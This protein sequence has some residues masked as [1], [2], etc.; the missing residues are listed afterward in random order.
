MPDTHPGKRTKRKASVAER[1]RGVDSV[2]ALHRILAE[3]AQDPDSRWTRTQALHYLPPRFHTRAEAFFDGEWLRTSEDQPSAPQLVDRIALDEVLRRIHERGAGSE[4]A[5]GPGAPMDT[6]ADRVPTPREIASLPD[7]IGPGAGHDAIAGM[8]RA[9]RDEI[10]EVDARAPKRFR[11]REGRCV[12]GTGGRFTYQFTWS[13]EPEPHLPGTLIV[14]GKTHRARVGE[15]AAEEEQRFAV[16]TDEYLGATIPVAEFRIDPTYLLALTHHQLLRQL[17]AR[18]AEAVVHVD[19]LLERPGP[20]VAGDVPSAALEGLNEEQALAVRVGAATERAYI[21]GPP[22]TGKTTTLGALVATLVRAGKRVLVVSPYNVAVDAAA[23]AAAKRDL[24]AGSIVRIGRVGDE[25]RRAG[26]DLDT[27]LEQIAALNGTLEEARL[28]LAALGARRGDDTPPP[29]T[30]RACLDELGAFVVASKAAARDPEMVRVVGAITTLR[31]RFR[32]PEGMILQGARVIACTMAL[33]LV[34]STLREQ[35]FD[36]VIVDEASVAHPPEAVLLSLHTNA[37][38]TFFGDPKQLPPIVIS[39]S[40]V[41][42]RWLGRSPFALAGIGRPS[43][44]V[45]ACVLLEEQHRM[46]PPISA[47]VSGMF[48]D[49]RLRNGAHA[50]THGQVVLIDTSRTAARATSRMVKMSTSKENQLHR[51]IVADVVHAVLRADADAGVLVVSPFVAQTRAYRREPTTSRLARSIRFETIHAS[52]GS[53]RDVVVID[54]VLAGTLARGGR[55]HMFNEDRNPHVGN[56]LN[57]A[58]S[59]AKRRLVIVGHRDL[60]GSAYAGGVLDHLLRLAATLGETVEVPKDLRSRG[61][62]DAVF[63]AAM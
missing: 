33:H 22:G 57:V 23:L 19:R 30:V 9:L 12:D 11:L 2:E 1:L 15:R 38:L 36:H 63:G 59:R 53:E 3:R 21:W 14:S 24:A 25:V 20:L 43:D 45:G 58:L 51:A 49:G 13:S 17:E 56:L 8:I 27:Q 46:A 16:V 48:Y 5:G 50:P 34:L 10:R 41:A 28:L 54:L 47:L 26:L 18:Q 32:A 6:D 60:L 35:R 62:F 37:P 61:M 52:Q 29:V 40:D 31:R 7:Y 42:R 39:R 44:A 55:S 4:A